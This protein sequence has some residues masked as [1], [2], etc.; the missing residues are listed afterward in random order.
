MMLDSWIIE[1]LKRREQRDSD[2]KK[3]RRPALELP[4]DNREEPI[5]EAEPNKDDLDRGVVI[6]DL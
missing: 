6:I 1:E 5:E 4:L 2:Q 3:P